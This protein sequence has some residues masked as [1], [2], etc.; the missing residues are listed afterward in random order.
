M[1]TPKVL[2]VGW[3][4]PPYNSGGLGEAC[5]GLAKAL[6][7]K[8]IE[9]VFVLPQ[10]VDLD[11]D[12]MKLEFANIKMDKKKLEN[13]YAAS[14]IF[15]KSFRKLSE[16][17]GNYIKA[18]IVYAERIGD[19]V[20]KYNPDIIHAHDWLTYPA[21]IVAK[22]LSGRPM[23][24]HVHS[25]ELDRTGGNN[26]NKEVYEI[27]KEGLIV[28]DRVLPV[29]GFMKKIITERYG[30]NPEKIKVIYNGIN[31]RNVR[32]LP[33]ALTSFKNMGYKIVLFLGRITLQK[34][35]EYFVRAASIV[36]KH[37]PKTIFVVTGS[38]D[39]Q[40][41]MMNETARL[42]LTDN[43]IYT[44]F[45]RGQERD[46]VFQAADLYVMPSVSEPFGITALEA[47]ANNTPALISKQSGVSEIF[48]HSLKV[49]F[50]DIDEMASKI[51]AC[52][53]YKALGVDLRRE[54]KKEVANLT[55]SKS[56]DKVLEV[57]RELV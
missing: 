46:M 43:F 55:W 29:G 50:W 37:K 2:M 6:S 4:L 40:E 33:P 18:A 32:M 42:G 53:K 16:L 24:A 19:I 9:I 8:G 48:Q 26:P 36:L 47:A 23:I 39:M 28:A 30:I 11:I 14:S 7:E 34:G 12:F 52:L 15:G 35:P 31:S 21:G 27:E 44:G 56:A 5:Y 45:L 41:Y 49:D 17:P 54:S 10:K 3:E 38:G 22:E 13:F 25:T 51:I 57:Y 20:E 1:T